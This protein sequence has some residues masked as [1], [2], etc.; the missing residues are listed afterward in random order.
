MKLKTKLDIHGRE[1]LTIRTLWSH[2]VQGGFSFDQ[3]LIKRTISGLDC[4]VNINW[5]IKAEF[6]TLY[7]V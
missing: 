3:I 1:N 5:K 4:F 6:G 7:S 2:A